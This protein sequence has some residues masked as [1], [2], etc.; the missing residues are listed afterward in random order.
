MFERYTEKARRVIFFARYEASHYGSPV[1]EPEHLLLGLLREDQSL[2]RA[3]PNAHSETIRKQIEAETQRQPATS[4][5]VDLPVSKAG[6][7]VLKQAA[8][9]AERLAHRHI[10]TEHLLLAL[11]EVPS[12]LAAKLIKEVGADTTKMRLEFAERYQQ[13]SPPTWPSFQRESYYGR[14]HRIPS[15]QTVEIHGTQWNADYVRD[16][17]K[18]VRTN[19]WHWHKA[20]WKP[21]DIVI[22]L[23][24]GAF[25]FELSLA[26]D[27]T[28]FALVKLGWKKDY[29][30]ICRWEM[31][32]SEDEHGMGYT[33][34]HDWL[35]ME[36]YERFWDRP[37]FFSSSHSEIT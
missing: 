29:C 19:N 6:Q 8:T 31:F 21:R 4:T 25:S 36:C 37:D 17:V 20:Q 35:C 2:F 7:M 26:E 18:L 14:G 32:D 22:N 3:F 28:K 9:E 30:F 5:S 15:P 33:N 27:A 24:N 13:L 12:T 11:A 34:G 23:K 1:I 16:A 10:G